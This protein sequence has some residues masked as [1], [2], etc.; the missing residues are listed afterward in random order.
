[1]PPLIEKFAKGV[2]FDNVPSELVMVPWHVALALGHATIN[3]EP[4]MSDDQLVRKFP[5]QPRRDTAEA[6][7][8]N[9]ADQRVDA[10]ARN[11]WRR[12]RH[13]ASGKVEAE[14]PLTAGE[15]P[16]AVHSW[17]HFDV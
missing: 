11:G 3:L 6:E 15:P 9:R 4:C 14:H 12:R 17:S 16:D 7:E 1:V 8:R 13:R 10:E 2:C 5:E